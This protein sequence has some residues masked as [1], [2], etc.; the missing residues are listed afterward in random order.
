MDTQ[1]ALPSWLL[2]VDILTEPGHLIIE[3][4]QIASNTL[5][6]RSE[7]DNPLLRKLYHIRSG[8]FMKGLKCEMYI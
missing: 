2:D 6:P 5:L 7:T 8:A 4:S 1:S 3:S